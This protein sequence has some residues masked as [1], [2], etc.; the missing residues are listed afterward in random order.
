VI[1]VTY[2]NLIKNVITVFEKIVGLCFGSSWRV[3]IFVVTMSVFTRCRHMMDTLLNTKH[4]FRWN[5]PVL[6]RS[7][8]IRH[9]GGGSIPLYTGDENAKSDKTATSVN[10]LMCAISIQ[11]CPPTSL[12]SG[13]SWHHTVRQRHHFLPF[14]PFPYEYCC[15][16]C[17]SSMP[18]VPSRSSENVKFK[19]LGTTVTK[20]KHDLNHDIKSR[21]N[22]GNVCYHS[23][24]NIL[25]IIL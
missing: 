2:W 9:L 10:V 17:T 19:Y 8:E 7:I 4:K 6:V 3:P 24:Q 18:A 14:K 23:T 21:F 12:S 1:P 15:F 20:T 16:I 22:F 11:G 13:R 25:S 5:I